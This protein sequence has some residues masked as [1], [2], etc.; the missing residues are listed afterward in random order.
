[1]KFKKISKNWVLRHEEDN[2]D[3]AINARLVE[4]TNNGDRRTNI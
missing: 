4:I 3:C 2:K 1:M